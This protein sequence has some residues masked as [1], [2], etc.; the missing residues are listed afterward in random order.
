MGRKRL[1][2]MELFCARAGESAAFYAWLLSSDADSGSDR[3]EPI[4]ILF[5][6]GVI[7]VRRSEIDGPSP[8]WVPVY[9]VDNVEE[10]GRRMKAEGGTWQEVEGRTYIVDAGGVWTRVVG[11]DAI[12]FGLDI[13]AVKETVLDYLTPDVVGITETYRQVLELDGVEVI[14]DPHSYRLLTDDR[15][16]A[17]GVVDYASAAQ[18]EL[19]TPS[20]MLYFDVRD[21]KAACARAV[22][23][24]A[25]VL[26]HPQTDSFEDWAVLVDPFGVTFGLSTYHDLKQ[27]E[28]LVRT[29]AGDV[30]PLHEATR[31]G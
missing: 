3:W 23:E 25:Q 27:S 26:I 20:W 6:R 31:L 11:A 19:K 17:M 10:T 16:I 9:L 30:V 22:R 18:G 2:G 12:P 21:V 13:E 1:V 8:M 14:G 24:G 15:Y 4:R 7:S 28:V 5:E 29:D